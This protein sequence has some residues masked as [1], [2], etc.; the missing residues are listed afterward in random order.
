MRV[1]FWGTRGSIPV[2][3]TSADVRDKVAE[4]LYRAQGRSFASVGE[5]YDY[6]VAHLD[7]ALTH[8]FGGHSPC[9]ELETG[10]EEYFVCDMGSGARP[11]GAH[12][13]ARQSGRPATVNVDPGPVTDSSRML[14]VV[15]ALPA[16]VTSSAPSDFAE[17]VVPLPSSTSR[18]AVGIVTVARSAVTRTT[19]HVPRRS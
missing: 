15:T 9:V 14:G 2:A 17:T 11:F 13:L 10:G 7:F 18:V 3:L 19:P 5:A 12:V 4:A 1:R 8:T 16:P 6:A